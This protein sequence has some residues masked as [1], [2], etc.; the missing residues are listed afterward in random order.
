MP[1]GL[2]EDREYEE[3]VF[4]AESGDVLVLYSDG[5]QDQLNLKEEEYG[6][7]RLARVSNRRG[8]GCRQIADRILADLDAFTDGT[9]TFD[10]QTLI[11]MKV[12]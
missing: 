2:L 9:A 8:S 7:T 3:I 1:A 11:V 10:D 12:R 4:Q 5:V 6:K